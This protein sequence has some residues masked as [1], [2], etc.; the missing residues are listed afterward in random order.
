MGSSALGDIFTSLILNPWLKNS[1]EAGRMLWDCGCRGRGGR[2]R[3]YVWPE[4]LCSEQADTGGLPDKT[5]AFHLAPGG[6]LAM[7]DP[8]RWGMD[9]GQPLIPGAPGRHTRPWRYKNRAEGERF[10]CRQ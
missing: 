10:P 5:D 6:H 1:T 7:T 3:A 8:T 4:F 2:V 9:K